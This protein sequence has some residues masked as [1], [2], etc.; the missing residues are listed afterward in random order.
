MVIASF[1]MLNLFVLIIVDQYDK[2][3]KR[4]DSPGQI[5]NDLAVNFRKK[6]AVMAKETNGI[7]LPSKYLI[8]FFKLLGPPLGFKLEVSRAAIAKAIMEMN[9]SG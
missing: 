5:F 9:L 1:I 3:V 6:W 4:G 8:D 7:K 2:Y